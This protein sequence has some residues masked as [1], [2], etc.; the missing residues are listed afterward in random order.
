[1]GSL[2]A[3][4]RSRLRPLAYAPEVRALA[5][6]TPTCAALVEPAIAAQAG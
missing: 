1:M 5:C 4:Q 2:G 3:G 6:S